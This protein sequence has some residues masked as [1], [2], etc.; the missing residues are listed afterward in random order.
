VQAANTARV[1]F[2]PARNLAQQVESGIYT[3][4]ILWTPPTPV[5][6]LK[7]EVTYSVEDL[8]IWISMITIPSTSTSYLPTT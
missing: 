7:L 1:F 4:S 3:F 8:A 6:Q 5:R 2:D